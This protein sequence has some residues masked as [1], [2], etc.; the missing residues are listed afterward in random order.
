VPTFDAA[1]ADAVYAALAADA[2]S[3]SDVELAAVDA[4]S[5]S[6]VETASV[7]S[8]PAV[9]S[10]YLAVDLVGPRVLTSYKNIF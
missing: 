2:A 10:N 1:S 3:D 4:V 6:G 7:G 9:L 5:D 8:G